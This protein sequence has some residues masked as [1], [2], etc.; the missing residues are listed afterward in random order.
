M[1]PLLFRLMY[2]VVVFESCSLD[3]VVPEKTSIATQDSRKENPMFRHLEATRPEITEDKE[4]SSS[5]EMRAGGLLNFNI[6]MDFIRARPA[7]KI[8]VKGGKDTFKKVNDEFMGGKTQAK[9]TSQ[10]GYRLQNYMKSNPDKWAKM[11][12]YAYFALGISLVAFFFGG[13][14]FLGWR[15]AMGGP[16]LDSAS[17]S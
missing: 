8:D 14:L 5:N 10:Q 7:P 6:L 17:F 11:A 1:G 13:F 12:Y 4:Q 15:P 16:R 2:L 9:L 3:Y